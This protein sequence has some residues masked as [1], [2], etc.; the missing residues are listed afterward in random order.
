MTSGAYDAS[1]AVGR[2]E[3]RADVLEQKLVEHMAQERLL[4]TTVARLEARLHIV[5]A[6]LAVL[7]DTHPSMDHKP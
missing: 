3:G 7:E 5:E 4:L 6:R 2:A 1:Y